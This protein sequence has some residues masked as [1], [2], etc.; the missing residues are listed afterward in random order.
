VRALLLLLLVAAA[1]IGSQTPPVIH[2]VANAGV[3]LQI[4]GAQFLIDAPIRDGIPPYAT[5]DT[6]D[7]ERLER[8]LPPYDRVDAILITH[9]HEDHFSAEAVAAHMTANT[10]AVLVSSA[11]VVQRVHAIAPALVPRL[12]VVLPLPGTVQ[13]VTIA[14][15]PVR[16]LRI[17]HNPARRFPEEHVGFLVGRSSTVLHTGDADPSAENFSILKTLPPIDVALL[18]F[19]Y[20]QSAANRQFVD[21]SIAPRRILAMHVPV[22]DAAKVQRTLDAAGV[23]AT[24]L[25]TP[26]RVATPFE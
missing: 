10:R 19:W 25:V 3:L 23:R 8:A 18:P 4:D 20:V 13:P 6:A 21:A 16:V 9:W 7:R 1:G 2:Y 22:A 15:V 12:R 26:G 11:E 5:S 24:L 14:G 17:R